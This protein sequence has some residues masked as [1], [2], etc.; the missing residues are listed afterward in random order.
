M[1]KYRYTVP[2]KVDLT[3]DVTA[4]NEEE[5]YDSACDYDFEITSVRLLDRRVAAVIGEADFFDATIEE[6]G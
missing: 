4:Q 2:V 3:L 5:A 6:M 1:K